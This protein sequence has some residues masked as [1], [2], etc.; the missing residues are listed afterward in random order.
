MNV[1]AAPAVDD[2]RAAAQRLWQQA[3]LVCSEHEVA[4]A[5]ARVAAEITARLADAY[6]LVLAVA[7]GAIVFAGE[8]LPR[9]RFALEFE[10]I[11]VSRYRDQTSGGKLNWLLAPQAVLRGRSVLV[12]DDILDEGMTLL[13]IRE[14]VMHHGARAFHSAVLVDKQLVRSKPL[15][16]DFVGLRV[17]D[18]YVFGCGMDVKGYWRN[19][20]AIYALRE[21]SDY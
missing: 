13:A 12:L 9:L 7:N 18:R 6:P 16:A 5:L 21:N 8:L 17:P 3:D 1:T 4:Q 2:A 19:L 11:R 14:H 15:R 10:V 20:P